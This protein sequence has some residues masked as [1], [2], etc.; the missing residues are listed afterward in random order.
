MVNYD[1]QTCSYFIACYS[2]HVPLGQ[3]K[4]FRFPFL[5][6]CLLE[7]SV[8][9]WKKGTKLK[10][11]KGPFLFKIQMGINIFVKIF[12]CNP[13]VLPDLK[14]NPFFKT[15]S[16]SQLNQQYIT[17]KKSHKKQTQTKRHS[18]HSVY[19]QPVVLPMLGRRL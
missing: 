4:F 3:D 14:E 19:S 2:F 18:W 15:L 5:L 6:M 9:Q 10:K 17:P 8:W 16:L 13:A 7:N 11:I 1:K 12:H